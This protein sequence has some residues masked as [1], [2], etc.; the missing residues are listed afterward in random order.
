MD[1]LELRA[2]RPPS[3]PAQAIA[4]AEAGIVEV[5]V[6]ISPSGKVIGARVVQ[7][8]GHAPID[9]AVLESMGTCFF[10]A[11]AKGVPPVNRYVVLRETFRGPGADRYRR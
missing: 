8:S 7:T 3:Y 10:P 9:Q 6:L 4:N 11:L 5:L 2:C 1:Q